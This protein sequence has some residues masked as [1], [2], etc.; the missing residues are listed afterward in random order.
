MTNTLA[1]FENSL[2]TA[3]KGFITL[4]LGACI[5]KLITAIIY[6]FPNNYS[7]CPWQAFPASSWVAYYQN[8][9]ITVAKG[10]I[11]LAQV[12]ETNALAYFRFI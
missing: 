4:A 10:L 12:P 9:K 2:I 7:V 3:A 11:K 6:G 8:F 1:Y 5:I